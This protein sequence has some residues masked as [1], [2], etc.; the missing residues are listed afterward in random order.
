[1]V[2]ASQRCVTQEIVNVT[3]F[4][5]SVLA[6]VVKLKIRITNIGLKLNGHC[7]YQSHKRRNTGEK[8]I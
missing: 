5:K 8:I 6:D 2:Y 3:L 4:G 1:M 7:P